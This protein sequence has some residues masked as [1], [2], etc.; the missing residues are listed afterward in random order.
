MVLK[1]IKICSLKEENELHVFTV[2]KAAMC[3]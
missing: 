2:S 1:C 3:S